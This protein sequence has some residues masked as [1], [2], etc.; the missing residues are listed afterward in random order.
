MMPKSKRQQA[1]A[2][3]QSHKS[4]GTSTTKT[5]NLLKLLSRSGGATID[6]L[7]NATGWQPHSVRGFLAGHIR[8]KLGLSLSS[9]KTGASDRRYSIK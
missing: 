9:E 7:C 3:L 1:K 4:G 8:K 2:K 6:E 5:D